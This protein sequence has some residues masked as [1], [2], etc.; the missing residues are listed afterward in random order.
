[1]NEIEIAFKELTK[2]SYTPLWLVDR[3]FR[4][5]LTDLTGNTHRA[6]FCID[7]LYSPDS[8]TGRLGLV[9]LRGFEMPPHYRMSTVQMLLIRALIAKFWEKPLDRKLARYGTELH[10]KYML[11]HFLWEDFKDVLQDLAENNYEFSEEWFKAFLDFRFPI[12]GKT[13]SGDIQ[14]EI[15][16]AAEPWLVLGEEGAPGGTAR[17]VDSSLERVQVRAFGL[18]SNRYVIACNRVKVPL[19]PT[20][21]NGEY[22]AGIRYRAWQPPSALHPT[23]GVHTPLVFD[24]IDT[25]NKKSIGGCTYHVSHPGGRLYVTF[26]V[27]ANEAETRRFS[28]FYDFGHNPGE[29]D[30]YPYAPPE[31]L[32]PEFPYTLDLRKIG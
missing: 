4:N 21:T 28:R 24:I 5:L 10:D 22:V 31:N 29:V 15:R 20:G 3:L 30:L 8:S 26:P 19:Q 11:P 18:T 13:I 27:N 7:K 9:E 32:N 6:E 16:M 1:M 2:N 12:Y 14:L 23:I 25:W 17:Y